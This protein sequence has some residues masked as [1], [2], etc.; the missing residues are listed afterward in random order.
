MGSWKINHLLQ[1]VR[2]LKPGGFQQK[3]AIDLQM[4]F[5]I[6]EA[7]NQ[8]NPA[9]VA[10][11]AAAFIAFFAFLRKAN[12]TVG[13]VHLADITKALQSGNIRIDNDS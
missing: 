13:K 3:A 6:A 11:A 12:V 9:E 8:N 5:W 1:G 10:F 2:R 4:L 7:T